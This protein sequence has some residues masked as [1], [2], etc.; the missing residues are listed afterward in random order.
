[1]VLSM[2][3]RCKMINR[4]YMTIS[5]RGF[6][7]NSISP[8]GFNSLSV[9]PR[10]LD[11]FLILIM[12]VLNLSVYSQTE[13]AYDIY[14]NKNSKLTFTGFTVN[15][16]SPTG[17]F[18]Q[19]EIVTPTQSNDWKLAGNASTTQ[20]VDFIGTTDNVGLSFRTNNIIRQTISSN[21]RVGIGT[22]TPTTLLDIDASLPVVRINNNMAFADTELRFTQSGSAGDLPVFIKYSNSSDLFQITA[23]KTAGT[24]GIIQYKR[25]TNAVA[26]GIRSG[27]E[28]MPKVGIGTTAPTSQLHIQSIVP[29]GGDD[30]LKLGSGDASWALGGIDGVGL[31]F[32]QNATSVSRI[33]SGTYSQNSS[34]DLGFFTGTTALSGSTPQMVLT[35]RG[36]VGIGIIN[37]TSTVSLSGSLSENV[38]VITATTALNNTHRKIVLNNGATNISIT[39]PDALTCL[40]RVYEFSRYA[41]STGTV[42]LNVALGN[43]VQALAGTVGTTTTLGAHSAA[44]AGLR[45]TFTA[46]NIGGI[47]VWVRL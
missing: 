15:K 7:S 8:R 44:G 10:G 21:G 6:N 9:S 27:S 13:G 26:I 38:T 36:E 37:P 19:Y 20:S 4:R 16:S 17:G 32:A 40:G 11:S 12:L 24:T 31:D 3:I 42:T 14:I 47:G 43:Q 22:T 2:E 25:G 35:Q 28:P 46:V 18:R 41:G 45:H 29:D 30:V 1:M 34:Y 5:P 39:L 33:K 23:S